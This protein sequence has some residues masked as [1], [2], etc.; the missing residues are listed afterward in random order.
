MSFLSQ[1]NSI[2]NNHN[3]K[4]PIS[5]NDFE[6]IIQLGKGN[7]APVYKSKYKYTGN[8]YAVKFI[9]QSC[10]K[11]KQQKEREL[12]FKREKAILYDLTKR[13]YPHTV[14][15]YADFED[16]NYRYLVLELLEGT[17]LNELQGTFQNN[18]YVDQQLIINILTQLLEILKYLHDTCHIMH[19]DIKPDNIILENNGN[20]KV[21]DFGISAYLENQFHN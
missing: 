6:I 20:I 21:F 17:Y 5:I 15:L 1:Q 2:M 12:D 11:S 13:D 3:F 14:K 8:I 18:G 16:D 7:F 9:E 19:R 10:F 4:N